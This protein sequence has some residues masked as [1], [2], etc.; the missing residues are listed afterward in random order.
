MILG[1]YDLFMMQTRWA[2]L[3]KQVGVTIDISR[4]GAQVI[5]G[6]GFLGAGTVLVTGR[7]QIKGLTTAAG[8]WASACMG[9]AIGAGFY[10]CVFFAFLMIL[11]VACV[12]PVVEKRIIENSRYMSIYVEFSSLDDLGAII[13]HIK[14]QDVSIN[15][16]DVEKG[17]KKTAASSAVFSLYLNQKQMHATFLTT[18][19]GLKCIRLLE[20]VD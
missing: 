11:I 7:Q 14:R 1:Q 4:F 18:L 15:A 17:G 9:L 8:L 6:I 12:L 10:E 5:N 13:A 3:A 20:E 19:S 16:V 2:E